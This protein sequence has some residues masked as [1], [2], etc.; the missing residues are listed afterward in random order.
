VKEEQ[1]LFDPRYRP[2]RDLPKSMG[3][4]NDRLAG[5]FDGEHVLSR[6]D[7]LNKLFPKAPV[8]GEVPKSEKAASDILHGFFWWS[9]VEMAFTYIYGGIM[10]GL[11]DDEIIDVFYSLQKEKA[12]GEFSPLFSDKEA[13]TKLVKAIR[14]NPN[15]IEISQYGDLQEFFED[16]D[17]MPFRPA[18]IPAS[19]FY[20][21]KDKYPIQSALVVPEHKIILPTLS[22]VMVV[23]ENIRPVVAEKRALLLEAQE[24][25]RNNGRFILPGDK[26]FLRTMARLPKKVQLELAPGLVL[27]GNV[28]L[29]SGRGD[30]FALPGQNQ[31]NSFDRAQAPG[32][33]DLDP[34]HWELSV[35]MAGDGVRLNFNPDTLRSMELKGFEPNVIDLRVG[36]SVSEFLGLSAPMRR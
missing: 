23:S 7:I 12:D 8:N 10:N 36:F 30:L 19:V 11:S 33:V 15:S 16:K 24:M 31:Y 4:T 32:G 20:D 34:A 28:S 27:P 22:Q 35:R 29:L 25:E 26:E 3:H 18:D 17:L 21:D 14:E 5:L 9:N 2:I 6:D 13:L 1:W